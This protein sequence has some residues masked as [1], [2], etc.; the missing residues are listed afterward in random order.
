MLGTKYGSQ[1]LTTNTKTG[2]TFEEV[3]NICTIFNLRQ[4][5]FHCRGQY[6]HLIL[7]SHV[8]MG[9]AGSFLWED[10]PAATQGEIHGLMRGPSYQNG[11]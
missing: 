6:N 10:E 5:I 2:G 8:Y 7:C 4:G 3:Q 9:D 1:Q 11:L